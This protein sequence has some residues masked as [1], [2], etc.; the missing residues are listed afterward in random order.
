[1][2]LTGT[3]GFY[4]VTPAGEGDTGPLNFDGF[5]AA[6]DQNPILFENGEPAAVQPSV[7]VDGALVTMSAFTDAPVGA[8]MT[9][10]IPDRWQ[11]WRGPRGEYLAPLRYELTI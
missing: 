1:M 2:T 6:C 3:N 11:G 10:C 8:V 7:T 4:F 5:A 9:I